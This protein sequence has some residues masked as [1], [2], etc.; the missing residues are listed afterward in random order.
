MWTYEHCLETTATPERLWRLYSDVRT[1][2]SWDRAN[3]Y[4]TLDGPFRAGSRG[5][6]KFTG[7]DPMPFTLVA[8]DPGRSFADE[9]D[10]GDLVIRFEHRLEARAGRTTITTR[11]TI[12]G[13][14][15]DTLGPELGPQITADIPA[16]LAAIA[17]LALSGADR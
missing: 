6:M 11:V 14:A 9:T 3:E 16:Q 13:P 10:L 15:A 5:S 7:Q 2:P 4:T 17:G 1:W 12:S 8:V